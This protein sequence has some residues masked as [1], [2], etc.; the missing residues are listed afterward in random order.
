MLKPVHL[1]LTLL[2]MLLLQSCSFG[3]GGERLPAPQAADPIRGITSEMY[4]TIGPPPT[5]I[6]LGFSQLG[7]ESSWRMANT[8][9][10]QSAAEEAGITLLMENAEQS[11]EKQ[12][13]AIRSFIRQKVDI[14][15]I[16]PVVQSGWEPI[17]QE[18]K[19]AGIPV[20]I[21][22]R[23]V[24]V[25]DNALYVTF[26]GSDFFEEGVKAGKYLLDKLRNQP[27]PVRIAEL[28]GTK[29]ST[30]SIDRGEGFRSVIKER[31]DLK[32]TQSDP[33]DFTEH[34]GYAVMKKLLEV[35][36]QEQPSVLFAHNDDMAIGAVR[37]IEE[38]GLQPG[39]DMIIISI[40]GTR[41]AFEQMVEGKINAVVECNPLLG[42]LLMQAAKEIMAGRTLPKRMVPQEDIF[43]KEMAGDEL[44]RR[45]F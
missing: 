7:T 21:I 11:Q 45:K 15:A 20:V 3:A 26:I 38:A 28:Q 12:F 9:S 32:I 34:Q 4:R 13:E 16:A 18:V 30:P 40:D 23:A 17:L 22:D 1:F 10:I 43:T 41:K 25:K 29:G 6:V 14:I 31:P 44:A 42:P 5:R 37:A 8:A 24:D 35:P 33:A 2:T 27:G 39:E 19:Q 36:K